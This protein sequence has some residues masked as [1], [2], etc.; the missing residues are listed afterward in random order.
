MSTSLT[1]KDFKCPHCGTKMVMT[2]I[3]FPYFEILENGEMGAVILNQDGVDEINETASQNDGDVEFH[4]PHCGRSYEAEPDYKT[5][6]YGIRWKVGE[7][8]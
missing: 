4:C 1:N 5:D 3:A 7:R 8:I 2:T 6:R